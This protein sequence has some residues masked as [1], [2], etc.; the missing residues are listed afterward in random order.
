MEAAYCS[1]CGAKF[2]EQEPEEEKKP[3]PDVVNEEADE[4]PET[5]EEVE[6]ADTE[7]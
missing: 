1:K 3:E 5:V 4:E 2:P 6:K 7:E